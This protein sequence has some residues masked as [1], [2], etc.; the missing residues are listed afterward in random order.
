MLRMCV[1]Q[2][3]WKCYIHF[4]FGCMKTS[5]SNITHQFQTFFFCF[6]HYFLKTF[7]QRLIIVRDVWVQNGINHRPMKSVQSAGAWTWARELL[8]KLKSATLRP[9]VQTLLL[10]YY[11]F[12]LSLPPQLWHNQNGTVVRPTDQTDNKVKAEGSEYL[13]FGTLALISLLYMQT[14]VC[15]FIMVKSNIPHSTHTLALNLG[16]T[17]S[18][19]FCYH[20]Q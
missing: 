16:T 17:L 19:I 8:I 2:L 3:Y 12:S 14:C 15:L 11:A 10:L 6:P 1:E 18:V 4:Q 13:L 5:K 20:V 9:S 7:N